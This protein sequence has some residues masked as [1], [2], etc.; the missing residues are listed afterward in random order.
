VRRALLVLLVLVVAVS[1]VAFWPFVRPFGVVPQVLLAL[2]VPVGLYGG[3]ILG[4]SLAVGAGLIVDL[5]GGAGFG[6]WMGQL[7]LVVLAGALVRRAGIEVDRV[8]VP[9]AIV[10]GATVLMDVVVWSS[11]LGITAHWPV[12]MLI[13]VMVIEVV[14]NWIAMVLVR[15]L[16]RWCTIGSGG[17]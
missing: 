12:G 10:V 1:Q 17:G 14:L 3:A 8:I 4:L 6:L 9:G 5:A 7:V 16:A 13:G 11:L 15:P 2:M